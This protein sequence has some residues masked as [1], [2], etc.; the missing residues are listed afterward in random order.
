MKSIIK[1]VA[2]IVILL[3]TTFISQAQIKNAKTE[4]LKVWGNCDMCKSTIEKAGNKKGDAKVIW[5][6]ETKQATI[7]Y[8]TAKTNTNEILK[9]IALAGYDNTVFAAPTEAYNNLPGCCQYDRPDKKETTTTAATTNKMS[10]TAKPLEQTTP[11]KA[12]TLQ[13]VYDAYFQLKDALVKSDANIAATKAAALLKLINEVK[14]ETLGNSHV[15]YMKVESDLKLHSEHI[16]E[17]KDIAHQRDHFSSL[18]TTMYQLMKVA[19]PNKNV[20]YDH[21]PMYNDGKGAN[22]LSLDASIKN[23]YYGSMM[24]TCGKVQETIKQ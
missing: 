8:N 4:T 15:A 10:A 1:V 22:W 19:K 14:M 24:L 21:C 23:P 7:T 17:S 20:Y 11:A 2:L 9:R 13:A 18:S 12:N 3:S 16:S 5:N 6:E